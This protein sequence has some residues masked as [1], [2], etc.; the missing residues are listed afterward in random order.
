MAY[1]A[2]AGANSRNSPKRS[3]QRVGD[4][5]DT[6]SAA[7]GHC[8]ARSRLSERKL[9]HRCRQVLQNTEDVVHGVNNRH[10]RSCGILLRPL[11]VGD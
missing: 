9:L 10:S 11:L 8:L 6:P 2:D 3:D 7:G 4:L 1:V 5:N